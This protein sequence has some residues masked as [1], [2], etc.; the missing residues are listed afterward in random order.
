[1]Q[2]FQKI[3]EVKDACLHFS[4]DGGVENIGYEPTYTSRTTSLFI[5]NPPCMQLEDR[6][7]RFKIMQLLSLIS[8]HLIDLLL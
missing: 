8:D 4:E 3:V 2:I 1:M 7:S 5:S 6:W